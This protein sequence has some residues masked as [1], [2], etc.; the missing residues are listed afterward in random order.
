MLARIDTELSAELGRA[1]KATPD[2]STP[3]GAGRGETAGQPIA[4]VSALLVALRPC[5][6]PEHWNELLQSDLQGRC[7]DAKALAAELLKLGWLSPYQVN[8]L[9]QGKGQELQLG[10]YLLL[11]R[12]GE[13]GAGQV[14]K[15]RHQMMNRLIALKLIRK[16]LLSDT[17]AVQ[18]FYREIQVVSKLNHPNVVRAYDAGAVGG[19]HFLA[20]EFIEGSDLGRLVKQGG[21]LP[22]LQACEYIRQAALGLQYAHER[23]VVHR[24]IKP[25]NM[26]ISAR[27]G[28]VKVA[29]L[30]LARL[31]RA[32]SGEVTA[33]L[34]GAG[35]TGTLT[36]ENAV[37]M[38]TA[39]YLAP[40][41][42]VD[43]HK[44]DIRA[45][46]YSLGCSL[47]F[48]LTGQPPFPGG[49]LATKV[50]RHL[51][52]E[53]PRIE[54]VRRDVPAELSSVLRRMLAKRPEQR[55]PTPGAVAQAL[56]PFVD[57]NSIT[58]P[59]SVPLDGTTSRSWRTRLPRIRELTAKLPGTQ[60][61]VDLART[62]PRPLLAATVGMVLLL[63]VSVVLLQQ[64]FS[65]KAR[66]ARSLRTLLSRRDSQSGDPVPLWKDFARFR[67]RYANTPEAEQATDFLR[68]D[69][70]DY[71]VS[72]PGSPGS[73]EAARLLTDLPSH[74]D[75]LKHEDLPAREREL[76]PSEVVAILPYPVA[77]GR[78]NGVASVG[79]SADGRVVASC[80]N[81]VLGLWEPAT[82]ASRTEVSPKFK[83]DCCAI[84]PNGQTVVAAIQQAAPPSPSTPNVMPVI[85]SW[86]VATFQNPFHF[87]ESL[88]PGHRLSFLLFS[89]DGRLLISC[90]GTELAMW[91]AVSGKHLHRFA[92]TAAR[93]KLTS[94]AFSPDGRILAIGRSDNSVQLFDVATRK[95]ARNHS[96]GTP[97]NSVAFTPGGE[98]LAVATDAPAIKLLDPA[99]GE[100]RRA[101][102]GHEQPVDALAFR[103][104]GSLLAS[105]GHDGT[106]RIWD[107]H[108]G[109]ER[110]QI[111]LGS[112]AVPI[113]QIAFSPDGRHLATANGNATVYILRI[114]PPSP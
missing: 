111:R 55:Y 100:E 22:V 94:C 69:L 21:P 99:S 1:K 28:L 62:R 86:N 31:P 105:A 45:D 101:L 19:T 3:S 57:A 109:T 72:K 30:G 48:L 32:V 42:A 114:A 39:D 36:P 75:G 83:I 90:A 52:T 7:R 20:M 79:I 50:A 77:Q 82:G 12:L 84:T 56:T 40:E 29:D 35:G 76:L 37:M 113:R 81:S 38:G 65:T 17:E 33:I 16:E 67:G 107:P 27:E 11:E 6:T 66:A 34:S 51:Q 58:T 8:Q 54:Q 61:L 71:R 78:E 9:L 87:Q 15:A 74:F 73:L 112:A 25:H 91:D 70:I 85:K 80:T 108:Q 98:L 46:I 96:L 44:A 4:S 53:P 49:T 60:R 23:G 97:V 47:Y 104:D 103:A 18:R 63:A 110:K 24:D 68:Q 5:L 89:P 88:G 10:S 93:Y 43:F 26:I 41:Q 14:F 92:H 64:A 106:I 95:D 13:G 59:I 102:S 2:Q